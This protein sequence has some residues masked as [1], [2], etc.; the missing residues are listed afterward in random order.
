MTVCPA[1][2]SKTSVGCI[3]GWREQH[4]TLPVVDLPYV[5]VTPRTPLSEYSDDEIAREYY[6]RAQRKLG[7]PS[8]G[9]T[10]PSVWDVDVLK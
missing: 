4:Q 8:I 9:V 2:G 3:C 1:C 5:R 6:W 10:V 7:D